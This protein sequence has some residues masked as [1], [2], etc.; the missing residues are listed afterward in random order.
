LITHRMKTPAISAFPA[1][2][3]GFPTLQPSIT[4]AA[5]PS[6]DHQPAN[7][8]HL[9]VHLKHHQKCRFQLLE[10]TTSSRPPVVFARSRLDTFKRLVRP[11]FQGGVG[12][13]GGVFI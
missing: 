11:G 1:I 9:S 6:S 5:R 10:E 8:H 7:K 2:C 4:P 3:S 13:V 12:D